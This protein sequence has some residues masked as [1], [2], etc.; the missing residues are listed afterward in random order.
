LL[1]LFFMKKFIVLLAL[2]L[3]SAAQAQETYRFAE[4]DT[5]SLYL[6]IYRPAAGS[7]TQLDSL[8][9]PAIM[10]VFGG[11]FIMGERSHPW[12]L[13]WFR[14]LNENGYTVVTVDYRLGMKGVKVGKGMSGALQASDAFENAQKMGVEDVISAVTFLL[15]QKDSLGI[16][17]YNMVISGSSAGAIISLATEYALVSGRAK[18]LPE[19]FNFKGVMSFA[20]GI[21]SNSGAPHFPKAPCPILLLHGTADQAVQYK[22]MA[23]FGKGIWGSYWLANDWK[24][25]GYNNYCIYRFKD[26]THDVAMYMEVLWDL[27]KTFLEQNVIRGHARS[28]DAL[29]DD[30]SLPHWM[31]ISLG[32]I[33]K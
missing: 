22:S 28:V 16:D 1:K 2:C 15:E 19:D 24:R 10:Y 20:G 5:C 21:I 9:K 12:H 25:A 29:V 14:T 13:P 26:S 27:E 33:Y 31:Q 30:A 3:G 6:D 18:G 8:D 17:P 11:G 32:D 4:R 7:Q 23:L